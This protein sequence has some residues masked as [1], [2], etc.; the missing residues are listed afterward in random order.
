MTTGFATRHIGEAPDAIAPDGSEVR[1][2]GS[3]AGGSMTVFRLR[4][5][6]VSRAVASGEGWRGGNCGASADLLRRPYGSGPAAGGF[7]GHTAA[8]RA[9][10]SGA[11]YRGARWSGGVDLRRQSLGQLGRQAAGE[12]CLAGGQ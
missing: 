2:L 8:G 10:R 7:V 12:R 3:L 5:N 11:A 6:A 1:L 4:P 9:A